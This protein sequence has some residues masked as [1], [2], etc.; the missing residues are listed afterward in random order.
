M[1]LMYISTILFL[2][3]SSIFSARCPSEV[4]GSNNFHIDTVQSNSR[5]ILSILKCITEINKILGEDLKDEINRTNVSQEVKELFYK[6]SEN[7]TLIVLSDVIVQFRNLLSPNDI[8][9]A[10]YDRSISRFFASAFLFSSALLILVNFWRSF[11]V[12]LINKI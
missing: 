2:I 1:F 5:K 10:N 12:V 9:I 3:G 8:S 6:E 7:F 4:I 11:S